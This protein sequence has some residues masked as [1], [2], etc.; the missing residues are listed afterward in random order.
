V[1]GLRLTS[2]DPTYDI[3]LKVR[4]DDVRVSGNVITAARSTICVLVGSVRAARRTVIEGNRIQRCGRSGKLDHLIYI[5]NAKGAVVR[6]NVLTGNPGGW[7]VHLYPKAD[8][9]LIEHNVIDGNQGGVIFAGDGP[10]T[11]DDNTVRYN[12][13]TYSSP[14]WNVEASWGDG[15]VGTGNSAHHNCLFST[16]PGAPAG[17]GALEGFTSSSNTVLARSPYVDRGRGDYRFPRGSRCRPLV[18]QVAVK[19]RRRP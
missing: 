10:D 15:P 9:T 19:P 1:R 2:H 16:G 11:S 6:R 8:G 4:G 7:A 5:Q 17:I 13:I 12:A 18:G 3:P 14:R